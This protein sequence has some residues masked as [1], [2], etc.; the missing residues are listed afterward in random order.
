MTTKPSHSPLEL[1]QLHQPGVLTWL[2]L[3]DIHF[4]ADLPNQRMVLNRLLDDIRTCRETEGW[5]PDMVFITGDIAWAGAGE[6]YTD[7]AARFLDRLLAAAAV[8]KEQVFV[9]PGNHDVDRN[10]VTGMMKGFQNDLLKAG[11]ANLA[12]FLTK[13]NHAADRVALFQRQH[14]YR[15]F[16][17]QHLP[18]CVPQVEPGCYTCCVKV[19]VGLPFERLWVLG[20]NTAWL[21]CQDEEHGKLLL[22]RTQLDRAFDPLEQSGNPSRDF[23][24][25]LTHH[26]L[27]WL[28][29]WDS[30]ECKPQLASRCDFHLSGHLHDHEFNLTGTTGPQRVTSIAAGSA[31]G[32]SDY[33]NGYHFLRL[34][35]QRQE[36][37]ALV[38]RFEPRALNTGQCWVADPNFSLPGPGL[39]RWALKH[40][41]PEPPEPPHL[42]PPT[43]GFRPLQAAP[44]CFGREAQVQTLTQALTETS[45]PVAISILGAG[46]IGK[47]NLCR[48]VMHS[49]EVSQRFGERRAFVRCEA[50]TD[51][52][53]LLKAI[54]FEINV[55]I[56]PHLEERILS[57]LKKAATLLVLDNF[58]TPWEAAQ[59]G[60]EDLLGYLAAVPTLALALTIRG[61]EQPYG[62]SWL[63]PVHLSPLGLEAARALFLKVAG[64][65]FHSDPHLD[66][67]LKDQSGL[68][69]A[70]ELLAYQAVGEPDLAALLSRWKTTRTA[71]LQRGTGGNR[72]T[73]L[74]IS[75]ELS[76]ESPRLTPEA[77]HLLALL[78]L[79]PNGV[80]H[81]DL[82]ELL[83]AAG[84]EAA[85][86]L[87]KV[88]LA[89]DSDDHRLRV[90][91]PIREYLKAH[92]PP[93]PEALAE[94][95]RHYLTLGAL[96]EQV[97]TAA[98]QTVT[99]RLL[100]EVENIETVLESAWAAADRSPAYRAACGLGK[101]FMFNGYGSPAILEKAVAVAG[102][103][104][105]VLEQADCILQLGGIA[106]QRS[107]HIEALEH[108]KKALIL[109][110]RIKYLPGQIE[111]TKGL[112]NLFF[113]QS[114]Y[115]K[116]QDLFEKALKFYEAEGLM[117]KQA[118]CIYGLGQIALR[119]SDHAEA[120]LRFEAALHF[121]KQKEDFLGQANCFRSLGEIEFRRSNHAKASEH[122]AAALPLFEQVGSVL[123]QAGCIWGFGDIAM[124][125]GNQ[126][127][128]KGHFEM[129]LPLYRQVGS[130]LGEANYLLRLG[131]IA[132]HFSDSGIAQLHCEKALSLFAKLRNIEGQANCL[133]ALGRIALEQTAY[134][135][136]RVY[137][138]K[139]LHLYEQAG[140]IHGQANCI[141]NL[142]EIEMNRFN[143][144][145]A[146][147][148]Y[149]EASLLFERVSNLQG[150]ANCLNELAKIAIEES[151]PDAAR[152]KFEMALALFEHIPEPYSIGWTHRFLARLCPAGTA[153]EAHLAAAR[154][155][156]ESIDRP[157]LVEELDDEFGPA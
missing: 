83:H 19:P 148:L 23:V 51:R 95:T 137:F 9:I 86:A 24:V 76:Y 91:A 107:N 101:L 155:A 118:D 35:F 18:H 112:G 131:E 98:G 66:E 110:E 62:V 146:Q 103:Y 21:A 106:L 30:H 104:S 45:P 57:E 77:R 132:F 126:L 54:A 153:R 136:A 67:L 93:V 59:V 61:V 53:A 71:L 47:S 82:T 145:N 79:L 128:A 75:V 39:H 121:Y 127:K 37:H 124:A 60:V 73:S 41:V 122:Y 42:L 12:E 31:Y 89:F 81:P 154:A 97:G 52:E 141:R 58:E 72:L 138:K 87:R 99:A 115:T 105:E 144:I 157:D 100:P 10:A 123:G 63:P 85:S 84:P 134:P 32:G 36:G 74:A 130:L 27:G 114:D 50:A 147:E 133:K 22:G 94:A 80:A 156:W 68:P 43:P 49:V 8:A 34:D 92:H 117:K 48:K 7:H 44:E 143:Y 65:K 5:A 15:V 149:E 3:S 150:Q 152:T 28:K 20:L 78:G 88:G 46:G 13:K 25:A 33:Y 6:E 17:E 4:K 135:V 140:D 70:V 116:A 26:P 55:E 38:R 139:A 14:A 111:C 120:Q 151:N 11:G 40:P 64:V 16:V 90:L 56:G 1:K 125:E 113:Q 108:F 2:H 96:G 29:E 109:F 119:Q 142:G 129:T 69:L 102:K